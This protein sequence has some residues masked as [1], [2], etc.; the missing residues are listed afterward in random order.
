MSEGARMDVVYLVQH[1]QSHHHLDRDARL[2]PDVRNGLTDLGK[3]QA[4]RLAERL[5]GEIGERPVR[6]YT[7][8]MQRAS[9]TAGIIGE[10]LGASP[11]R[12]YDLHENNGRFAMERTGD[13]VEWKVEDMTGWSLFDWR[14]FPEAETWREFY[15][16]VVTAMD[17]IMQ[18]HDGGAAPVF[19]VHGGT[20]SNIVVWWLRLPLDFLPERTCFTASPASLSVLHRNSHGNPVVE[21]LNDRA[22]LNGLV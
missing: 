17:G 22:H 12:V 20:L 14:P 6:V 2:W 9:E 7:S 16:R 10:R 1:C 8:P 5:H 19:V 3:R 15:S 4:E 21:R 18:R 11:E 13:G